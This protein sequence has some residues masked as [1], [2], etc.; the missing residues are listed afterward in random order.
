M[1]KMI[2][3]ILLVLF[4]CQ[5]PGSSIHLQESEN[6][7]TNSASEVSEDISLEID[8]VP[9]FALNRETE[10]FELEGI[11]FF[12]ESL[13]VALKEGEPLRYS[14][15]NTKEEIVAK[16]AYGKA[17][18]G[19]ILLGGLP[20]GR[21][22]LFLDG[23]PVTVAADFSDTW[24]TVTRKGHAH[25]VSVK[26]AHG[27]VALEVKRVRKLPKNIYDI[28]I[29]PGHGGMDTGTSGNGLL[30]SEEVLKLSLY[31][32]KRFEDHGLK[33]K[34]TR[35]G[36]YEMAGEG[37][38]HAIESPYYANGRVEQ[39]YRH[40]AKYL[41]S[42]HL[43]AVGGGVMAEGYEVYTSILTDDSWSGHVSTA[44]AT[45]GRTARDSLLNDYRVSKGS[46]KKW[47]KDDPTRDYLYILRESGGV[48]SQST[49]I[50]KYNPAY[51]E[52][53][54]HG[55]EAMLVEYAYIDNPDEAT[56][57]MQH[58]EEWA[59]AVVLGTLNYL[60]IEYKER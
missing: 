7:E 11:H 13:R 43:N 42:N 27:L 3:A 29:D 33:V 20:T 50:V 54:L 30:E 2:V 44:L 18:N 16:G 47:S 58:Y 21:F 8:E 4:A 37:N 28:L 25:K 34:L 19:G 5:A 52:I 51:E 45:S 53:P 49:A 22:Y 46:F 59:E 56:Q 57:W 60:G 10:G 32:A 41:I 48:L 12:G 14:L 31:M 40:Q 24:Y 38:Y 17:N 39:A 1:K 15:K 26:E 55:A 6:E 23:Q 9:L 36:D 35:D